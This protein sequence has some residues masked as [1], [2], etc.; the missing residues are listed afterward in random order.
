[1]SREYRDL[2][3]I[4]AME[5]GDEEGEKELVGDAMEKIAAERS[6]LSIDGG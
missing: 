6:V 5:G 1:M 2:K 4:A 3:R